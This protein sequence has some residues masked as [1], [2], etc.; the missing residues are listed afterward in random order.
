MVLTTQHS[1]Y[2]QNGFSRM[3]DETDFL[4]LLNYAKRLLIGEKVIP[5][6]DKQLEYY[7]KNRHFL[8]TLGFIPKKSGGYRRIYAPLE[9]LKL[10]QR[11]LNLILQAVFN[12]HNAAM[13]FVLNKTI[14]DNASVHTGNNY[15]YNIDLKDFFDSIDPHRFWVCM[16]NT[17]FNLNGD[18]Q[19]IAYTIVN[20][21]F[22]YDWDLE[23]NDFTFEKMILPQ[24]APTSPIISNII[25][26]KLDILLSG[27]AKR[28]N[29]RYSRYADDITFSSMH[30]VYQKNSDFI[31]ELRRIIQDQGFVINEDKVRLQ[32]KSTY[33]QEVTGL[34]VNEKVN[35]KREY[36]KRLRSWLYL[37][38]TYGYEKA[39]IY[40]LRDYRRDRGY[41]IQE[42]PDF[43]QTLR[44]KLEYL[45][46]VIGSDDKRY[47]KLNER[48]RI[49]YEDYKKQD[50]SVK[51]GE[52]RALPHQPQATVNFLRLFENREAFKYLT[53]DFDND[54]VIFS[55][56]NI[57]KKAK[58]AYR[59]VNK[60][61]LPKEL[62]ARFNQFAFSYQPEWWTWEKGNNETINL[63]WSGKALKNWC[64]DALNSGIHPFKSPHYLQK[65][66][67]P[68]KHCIEVR[69]G[70][71]PKIFDQV[72][73]RHKLTTPFEIRFNDVKKAR[74]YTDVNIFQLGLIKL[75]AP[76]KEFAATNN[77]YKI[78][79]EF[80]F[81]K[82][83]KTVSRLKVI[84]IT[85]LNSM[86]HK[87]SDD[88]DLIKGDLSEAKRRFTGLCNW[89]IEA[90]F[91][92]G[93]KRVNILTDNPETPHIEPI[94]KDEIGFT[95]ILAFY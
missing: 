73:Q 39:H 52:K 31:L 82:I 53:H 43:T 7:T 17:P 12:P 64:D 41:F 79:I 36:I 2:I 76:F 28:F 57:V 26:K 8:Y 24:G 46:V 65:M 15:V 80:Y 5:F 18:R 21:C 87:F 49:L 63:G 72:I 30:N 84:K 68:F 48:Y 50:P 69:M 60:A 45:K 61:V 1:T 42:I 56:E 70:Y 35:I 20:L 77:A 66:I 47:K 22:T 27:V 78:D 89:S 51:I 86:P 13:G 25:G 67:N 59:H 62:L 83:E 44:G 71:L 93:F 34:V 75:F 85:H 54:E 23:E 37:W 33:R 4:A 10:I 40:F 90:K 95:H 58:T 55:R 91:E 29:L 81:E 14:V 19:K 88:T 6:T 32:E 3:K 9:G 94:E 92:D 74:F 16:Q 38:E 11:S